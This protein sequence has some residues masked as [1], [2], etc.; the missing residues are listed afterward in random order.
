ML[1]VSILTASLNDEL[2]LYVTSFS[3]FALSLSSHWVL[4]LAIACREG[5]Q[6]V[7]CVS[8]ILT[9]S[10]A[11]RS[12]L[13]IQSCVSE[14]IC[15]WQ[16]ICVGSTFLKTFLF[17]N[18]C[19]WIQTESRTFDLYRPQYQLQVLW[20]V[21]ARSQFQIWPRKFW[22]LTKFIVILVSPPP[23]ENTEISALLP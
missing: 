13:R 3:R 17:R 15:F 1:L 18:V 14:Y 22:S 2:K 10:I 20:P 6:R 5:N 23:Q 16:S 7:N 19:S 8:H 4:R 11:S 9:C 21:V 12:G